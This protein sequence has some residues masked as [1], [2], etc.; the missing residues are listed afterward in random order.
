MNI[1]KTAECVV[2]GA[3][4]FAQTITLSI[5]GPCFIHGN[6]RIKIGQ[7]AK[8]ELEMEVPYPDDEEA[9]K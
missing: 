9:S 4:M 7:K 8:I 2:V 5:E 3:D 6:S 1:L